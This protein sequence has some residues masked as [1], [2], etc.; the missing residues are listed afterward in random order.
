[1]R[2][3]RH[4]EDNAHGIKQRLESLQFIMPRWVSSNHQKPLRCARNSPIENWERSISFLMRS[5]IFQQFDVRGYTSFKPHTLW[6]LVVTGQGKCWH[7]NIPIWIT[8][9]NIFTPN[10]CSFACPKLNGSRTAE[11][12]E[13]D[14]GFWIAPGVYRGQFI[15]WIS[16]LNLQKTASFGISLVFPQYWTFN[17]TPGKICSMSI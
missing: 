8:Q 12:R 14:R 10:S 5:Q 13:G 1:M 4:I 7:L 11:P 17:F 9:W 3:Y 16:K 15:G 6:K 2:G